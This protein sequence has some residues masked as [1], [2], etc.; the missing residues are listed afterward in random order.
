MSDEMKKA[1]RVARTLREAV[2]Q[3]REVHLDQREQ[4]LLVGWA[5]QM[6]SWAR[7]AS[8]C[9]LV[10][11]QAVEEAEVLLERAPD[12]VKALAGMIRAAAEEMIRDDT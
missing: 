4:V 7:S 12:D 2:D 11:P 6:Y 5:V 10:H 9:G 1:E 3:T 8:D